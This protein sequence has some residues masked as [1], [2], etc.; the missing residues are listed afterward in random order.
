[1]SNFNQTLKQKNWIKL[2]QKNFVIYIL[3]IIVCKR[4]NK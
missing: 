3:I 1:M 2:N 4:K